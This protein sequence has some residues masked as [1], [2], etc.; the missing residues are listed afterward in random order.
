MRG[1]CRKQPINAGLVSLLKN[2]TKNSNVIILKIFSNMLIWKCLPRF[3]IHK[4]TVSVYNIKQLI[5]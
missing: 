5:I 2:K 1:Y 3:K 4:K